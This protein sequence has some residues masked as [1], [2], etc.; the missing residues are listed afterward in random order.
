MRQREQQIEGSVI[1]LK[2]RLIAL[3]VVVFLT[4]VAASLSFSAKAQSFLEYEKYVHTHLN[5]GV[6]GNWSYMEKPMFP[7]FLTILRCK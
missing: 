5:S 2:N 7:V 1:T 4:S 6:L 3:I